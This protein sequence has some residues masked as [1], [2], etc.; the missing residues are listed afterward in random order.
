MSSDLVVAEE[1]LGQ[2]KIRRLASP[3]SA[4]DADT[5]AGRIYETELIL[6]QS[7]GLQ[8]V[9]AGAITPIINPIVQSAVAAAVGPAVQAAFAQ[10]QQSI[11]QIHSGLNNDRIRRR[12]SSVV[13]VGN[14]GELRL[15]YKELPGHPDIGAYP[16]LHPILAAGAPFPVGSL[17]PHVNANITCTFLLGLNNAQISDLAFFYNDPLLQ[18]GPLIAD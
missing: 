4:V 13:A 5:V 1:Y 11:A 14:E 3:P 6:D 10:L 7:R 16:N 9:I 18:A 2:I 8:A 17:P 15:L 12:N